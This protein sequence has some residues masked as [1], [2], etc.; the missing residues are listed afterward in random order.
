MLIGHEGLKPHIEAFKTWDQEAEEA[1]FRAHFVPA[2]VQIIQVG[3]RDVG[4]LK[5][6]EWPDCAYLDGIYLD[7]DHRS[8]GLGARVLSELIAAYRAAGVPVR[9]RV[10]KS[11]PAQRL[12]ERL[13]FCVIE[14]T[15]QAWIMEVRS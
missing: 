8:Q 14:E 4:Y 10:Y 12:Y 11:N 13:G 3:E 1:G 6:E 9:L 2:Q 15:E 7:R 5:I